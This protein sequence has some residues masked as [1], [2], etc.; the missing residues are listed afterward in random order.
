MGR[1]INSGVDVLRKS[2][3][4]LGD[5]HVQARGWHA[6]E[7]SAWN[8]EFRRSTDQVS[9]NQWFKR[10]R[11]GG[12]SCAPKRHM[13]RQTDI[14]WKDLTQIQCRAWHSCHL[15]PTFILGSLCWAELC[16]KHLPSK[17]PGDY[18]ML[19]LYLYVL[20]YQSFFWGVCLEV[21][22]IVMACYFEEFPICLSISLLSKTLLL[23]DCVD[24]ISLATSLGS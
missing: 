22:A 18:F 7:A 16:H 9:L 4:N 14:R 13:L 8:T 21:W 15:F 12:A 3:M 23:D 19:G 11:G 17:T 10:K 6:Q 20:F 2:V 5:Q 1:M 24:P